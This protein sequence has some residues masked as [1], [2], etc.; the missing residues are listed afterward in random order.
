MSRKQVVL[1]NVRE[2]DD[3]SL[4]D[5]IA[6]SG[7][8]RPRRAPDGPIIGVLEALG[9][10]GTAMVSLPTGGAPVTAQSTVALQREDAGR[11]VLVVF[12]HNDLRCPIVIG[13]LTGR[14]EETSEEA[15]P[16]EVTIDG[17]RLVLT[18]QREVV[19]RCGEA[20][21]TLTRAGKV[22]IRG[23]ALFSRSSGVNRIK[24]ASVQIN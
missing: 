10:D 7:S 2:V 18:A 14:Q 6:R 20:S 8:E 23:T 22:V 13:L 11:R 9:E 24:G 3:V 21:I 15:S 4:L 12:E 5:E 1:T 16:A 17:D 19:L